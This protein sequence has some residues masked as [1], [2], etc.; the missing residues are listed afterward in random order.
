VDD[1]LLRQALIENAQQEIPDTMNRWNEIQQKL[2]LN[3]LPTR[4][5]SVRRFIPLVAILLLSAGVYALYQST[6][7]FFPLD[8]VCEREGFHELG[9]SQTVDGVT[10]HLERAYADTDV[11]RILVRIEGLPHEQYSKQLQNGAGILED[12]QGNI[13][14]LVY[15]PDAAPC[16]FN[17]ET[18]GTKKPDDE[19]LNVLST[20]GLTTADYNH[21]PL[22]TFFETYY[23]GIPEAF[24]LSYELTLQTEKATPTPANVEGTAEPQ[25]EEFNDLVFRFDFSVPVH[26]EIILEPEQIV[27]NNGFAVALTEARIGK[28]STDVQLCFSEPIEVIYD[29]PPTLTLGEYQGWQ[30]SVMLNEDASSETQWCVDYTY[31]MYFDQPPATL[32]LHIEDLY[33]QI[34]RSPAARETWE[35]LV[36][37]AAEQG[38]EVELKTYG[39]FIYP[40]E[41][42]TDKFTGE[43]FA[44]AI[45]ELY[46]EVGLMQ[47]LEGSWTFTVE[48]PSS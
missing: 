14:R 30:T 45:L 29:Q 16:P 13:F 42:P 33:K 43:S 36:E 46:K 26:G 39:G 47:A 32:T 4:S 9:L 6:L 28:S 18:A 12:E 21:M 5:R 25:P 20:G 19:I 31:N 23:G 24:N 37:A 27:E 15:E 48:I 10:V 2:P 11:I 17:R 38:I 22:S 35:Q 3:A 44:E 8:I 1:K 34:D 7:S 40:S 41:R